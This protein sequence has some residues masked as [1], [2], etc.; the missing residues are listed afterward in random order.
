MYAFRRRIALMRV[1]A[2]ALLVLPI[3]P[4]AAAGT[5]AT[6]STSDLRVCF[7]DPNGTAS[8]KDI[9]W[10]TLAGTIRSEADA[11]GP[12]LEIRGSVYEW[13]GA[14]SWVRDALIYAKSKGAT[15]R[16]IVTD[17][18]KYTSTG[19]VSATYTSLVSHGLVEG[20]CN[21]N[22]MEDVSDPSL[23]HNKFFVFLRYGVP[24]RSFQTSSNFSE[25]QLSLFNGYVDILN[26]SATADFYSQY[27]D[28]LRPRPAYTGEPKPYTGAG[29]WGAWST[30]AARTIAT[31]TFGRAYAFPRLADDPVRDNLAAVTG[32]PSGSQVLL[33]ASKFNYT[34]VGVLEQLDR[35]E[36]LGC[37]VRVIVKDATDEYCVQKHATWDLLDSSVKQAPL[38]HK[39]VVIDANIGSTRRN[40]VLTGSHNITSS[41]LRKNNEAMLRL[42]GSHVFNEHVAHFNAIASTNN[43]VAP[44]APE[45]C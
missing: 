4:A 14:D 12:G 7:S 31:A 36:N 17:Q 22:C 29:S 39:F 13:G 26:N 21:K 2:A 32:C 19:S 37:T 5:C 10:S 24:A 15:V 30:D 45:S 40:F 27:W 11:R 41:S 44:V 1:V 33:A 25:D 20:V 42:D 34:R 18:V 43:P 3:T 28:R 8:D 9:I 23:N 38:H 16:L 35:L 6:N